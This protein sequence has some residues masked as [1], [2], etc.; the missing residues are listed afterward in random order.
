[1][2]TFRINVPASENAIWPFYALQ[3]VKKALGQAKPAGAKVSKTVVAEQ[4]KE[5]L[6]INEEE[7][8]ATLSAPAEKKRVSKPTPK[9]AALAADSRPKRAVKLPKKLAE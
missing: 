7:Q 3:A 1:M 8:A 4:R 5:A 2:N 6:N 9:M